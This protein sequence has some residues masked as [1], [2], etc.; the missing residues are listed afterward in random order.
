MFWKLEEG[1]LTKSLLIHFIMMQVWAV[2]ENYTFFI[3]FILDFYPTNLY[4]WSRCVRHCI[5]YLVLLFFCN[6]SYKK[7]KCTKPQILNWS[8]LKNGHRSIRIVDNWEKQKK[9]VNKCLLCEFR[10]ANFSSFRSK[11]MPKSFIA[12]IKS[13]ASNKTLFCQKFT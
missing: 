11:E 10:I 6:T 13:C 8:Q 9:C 2:W 12:D 7:Y 1:W 3:K 5:F 4:K